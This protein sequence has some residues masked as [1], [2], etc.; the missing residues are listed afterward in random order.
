V[1]LAETEVLLAK[2][3]CPLAAP[4]ALLV[5]YVTFEIENKALLA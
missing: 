5:I 2:T 4:D 3:A 1:L